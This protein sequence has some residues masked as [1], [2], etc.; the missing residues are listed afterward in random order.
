[1]FFEKLFFIDDFNHFFDQKYITIQLF[2]KDYL[3]K[4]SG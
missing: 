3:Y 2:S 1:M 4:I